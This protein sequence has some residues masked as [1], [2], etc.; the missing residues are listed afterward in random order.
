MKKKFLSN[1]F[2]K[3][4]FAEETNIEWTGPSVRVKDGKAL[5]N[6]PEMKRDMEAAAKLAAYH[7][8]RKSL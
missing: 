7:K 3:Q 1:I 8:Q 4:R 2:K 5:L 6:S